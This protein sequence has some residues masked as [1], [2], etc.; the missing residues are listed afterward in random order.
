LRLQRTVQALIRPDLDSGW[1]GECS[2]LHTVTQGDT[3]DEVTRNLQEAIALALEDED[4]ATL[5]LTPS[6]V[7]LVTLE[8][9]PMIA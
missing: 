6:P 8:L 4:L 9:E 5:G 7:I 1:I 2:Q 3:L